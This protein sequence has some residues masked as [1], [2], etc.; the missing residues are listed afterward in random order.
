MKT[1]VYHT[2]EELE[3]VFNHL[4]RAIEILNPDEMSP[5]ELSQGGYNE[6]LQLELFRMQVLSEMR[7][8]YKESWDI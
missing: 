5:R 7:E 3:Q 2:A 1:L 8:V 4:G 6:I